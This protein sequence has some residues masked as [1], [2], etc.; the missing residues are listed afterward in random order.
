MESKRCKRC[1][2][3]KPISDFG[4]NGSYKDGLQALCVICIRTRSKGY[5]D[6]PE[7]RRKNRER[8]LRWRFGITSGHYQWM[9][10]SQGG[11]CAICGKPPTGKHAF[12]VDHCHDTGDIRGLLC[13]TCNTGIGGLKDDPNLLRAAI[14]YLGGKPRLTNCWLST[15]GPAPS[16][17]PTEDEDRSIP[18]HASHS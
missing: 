11:V 3:V 13:S 14:A 7:N 18:D 8:S 9:L 12:H 15:T 5:R 6:T 17:I 10:E 4:K 16:A 1:G 2:E